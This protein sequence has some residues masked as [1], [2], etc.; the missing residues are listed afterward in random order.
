M[1]EVF[2][3]FFEDNNSV[4]TQ[5]PGKLPGSVSLKGVS[6]DPDTDLLAEVITVLLMNIRK[7][8]EVRGFD[9]G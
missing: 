6:T 3:T 2:Q 5:L 9:I 7:L 8:P 1:A 4:A